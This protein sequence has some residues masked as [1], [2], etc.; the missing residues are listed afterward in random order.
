MLGRSLSTIS[1]EVARNRSADGYVSAPAQTLCQQRLIDARPLPKLH[2][3]GTL[4]HAVCDL[5]RWRWPSQ[6]IAA[7]LRRMYPQDLFCRVSHETIYNAIHAYPRD[8]L[9][10]QL[11]ALLRQGKSSHRFRSAGE[12]RCRRIAQMPSIHVRPLEV[13]DR[14]MPGHWEGDLIKGANSQS[15]VGVRVER[16]TRLVL[17][18][19]MSDAT[20]ESAL[21]AF[22]AKLNLIAAPLRQTLT[23]EQSK[24]MARHQN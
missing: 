23:Y 17:L 6:Q 20:T 1:R 24:E 18:C 5:L 11:T 4:W 8:E 10:K 21:V 14:L 9:R 3:S 12:D 22:A 7:T 16:T 2:E 19:K 15:A 13:G